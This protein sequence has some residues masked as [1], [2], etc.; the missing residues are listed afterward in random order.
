MIQI[1]A[2][3][4]G[5]Y[6][7]VAECRVSPL[8]RGFLFG[9]AVY[10]LIPVYNRKA[11]CMSQH[12]ARLAR[13]VEQVHIQNPY[14][15][16]QWAAIIE[17]LI[18]QSDDE[19]LAVYIQ[20]TRGVAK[21][22]HIF[23]ENVNPTVFAMANPMARVAG[24]ELQNGVELITVKDIRWQ[25]C[26][27]KVTGLLANILAKQEAIQ[28]SAYEAILIRDGF[29]LEGSASNL[30]VV[31]NG[32]VYTHPEDNLVLP[33]V[34]RDFILGLLNELEVEFREQAIPEEWLYSANELW[35]TS[36][37]REILAATKIDKRVVGKGVPGELWKD[38][39]AL[40]Q[41]SIA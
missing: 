35:V 37:A 36:S 18:Q 7:P 25:R 23:P 31:R 27:I 8:D 15:P 39:H 10:E 13:S 26:D 20:V 19:D 41:K 6:M 11:F 21:R 17:K 30:F 1:P 22:D 38:V 34:T 29:A 12:L 40:Y 28:S 24:E 33:G 9:D 32:T 2:F 16:T 5:E 3:L 14:T 4:N